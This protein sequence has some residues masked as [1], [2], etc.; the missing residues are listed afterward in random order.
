MHARTLCEDGLV[1]PELEPFATRVA[2]ETGALEPERQVSERRLGEMAGLYAAPVA[3]SSTILVYR[4]STVPVPE[5]SSD[6]LCC[7]T[8][9]EPGLVDDEYFMTA[10]HYHAMR[11]RAETYLGLAGSGLVI[12]ADEAGRWRALPLRAGDLAYIPGGWAHRTVNAGDDQVRFLST[13]IADA[14]HDY[15]TIRA[16]GFP[17]RVVRRAGEPA[18]VE[19][20]AFRR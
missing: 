14:G 10:G 13:W 16:R 3:T 7:T 2:L 18:V 11:D 20:A 12:L 6:L 15:A 9:I 17:V 5:R 19:N 1:Q 8:V 4:V